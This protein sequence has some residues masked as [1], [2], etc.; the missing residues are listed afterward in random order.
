MAI[1]NI[2]ADRAAVQAIIRAPLLH[3]IDSWRATL[4]PIPPRSVALRELA[5]I[6][7]DN[8]I[9]AA[10]ADSPATKDDRRGSR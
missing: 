3:R 1:H 10:N 6:A 8:L 4:R 9:P 5:G 7:L 2:S